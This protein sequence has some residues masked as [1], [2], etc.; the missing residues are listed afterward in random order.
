MSENTNFQPQ[1]VRGN[2]VA[3][4]P[5]TGG[6]YMGQSGTNETP[7]YYNPPPPPPAPHLGMFT[8]VATI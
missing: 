1:V 3:P 2:Q 5:E 4:A 7:L 6:I 8:T